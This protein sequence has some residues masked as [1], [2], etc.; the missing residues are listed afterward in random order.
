MCVALLSEFFAAVAISFGLSVWVGVSKYQKT[1][2]VVSLTNSSAVRPPGFG[3]VVI[4]TDFKLFRTSWFYVWWICFFFGLVLLSVLAS[5]LRRMVYNCERS[6]K[7]EKNLR[8]AE[9]FRYQ[10]LRR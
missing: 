10:L 6:D 2:A 1:H 4:A 9:D 5:I 7:R 8:T 3:E